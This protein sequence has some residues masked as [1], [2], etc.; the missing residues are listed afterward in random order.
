MNGQLV[1]LYLKNTW[2][3]WVQ[4]PSW[5]F[6][7]VC[8]GFIFGV[9]LGPLVLGLSL[10][11]WL[12]VL[13]GSFFLVM[14]TRLP[15]WRLLFLLLFVVA[16]GSFR[17]S[18]SLL[19]PNVETIAD[20]TGR[21][22][23]FSGVVSAE[24]DRRIDRQYITLD[25]LAVVERAVDGKLLL[26]LPLYP[27][28]HYGDKVVFNGRV[29][30]PEPFE[31]FAYDKYLLSKGV[32][33]V[34][35]NPEDLDVISG[36]SGGVMARTL[37]IKALLLERLRAIVPEPQ[38]AFLSGLLFGGNS[39]LSFDLKDDFARTG[40]SHV[41]AASGFNVSLFSLFLLSWLLQTPLGR[42]RGLLVIAGFLLFY[43]IMAGATPAVVRAVVMAMWLL[44][45]K[46]VNRQA[47]MRNVILLTAA[48]MLAL[49]PLLL[50][51]DVGFQLSFV[52]IVAL[53]VVAPLLDPYFLFVPKTLGVRAAFVGSIAAIVFTLPLII[54]H[55]GAISIVAPLVNMLT[56]PL[57]P[58]L[59]A[60]MLVALGFALVST[61]AGMLAAL[62]AW[63]VS[64][65][66]L[67]V[68][69]WFSEI[70]WASVEVF[71]SRG[72]ALT[73]L[74]AVLLFFWVLKRKEKKRL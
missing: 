74:L 1:L 33:A 55:F 23:R 2:T 73:A 30:T 32:L 72:L 18:Q 21:A 9:G 7:V 6:A 60:L 64:T 41:L 51:W 54:W 58:Y 48:L 3:T 46:W 61:G 26:S 19:P 36:E 12:V 37:A 70:P 65:M 67:S 39:S 13:G 38:A 25:E 45:A 43:T 31:G 29:E 27:E 56:L 15:R 34:C 22:S 11:A 63:G 5:S 62:P 47:S 16:F 17:Y 71:R 50:F 42:K 68:I 44:I 8:S 14:I 66:L 49:N 20:A 28:V 57:I 40:V 24:V 52:A 4:S 69:V 10:T 59:M 53:F 35:W